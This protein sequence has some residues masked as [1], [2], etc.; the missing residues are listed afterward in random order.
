MPSTPSAY[1]QV[2]WRLFASSNPEFPH[3]KPFSAPGSIPGSST[4]EAGQGEKP[5]Q[6]SFF[7]KVH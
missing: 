5:W 6:L 7:N 3:V 4:E 2:A 1:P